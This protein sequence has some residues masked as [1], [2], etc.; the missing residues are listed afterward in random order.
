MQF[1]YW[2]WLLCFYVS[3]IVPQE[4]LKS[5]WSP[6]QSLIKGWRW[7]RDPHDRRVHHPDTLSH[8]S[9]NEVKVGQTKA[10]L[11]L[12]WNIIPRR[13]SKYSFSVQQKTFILLLL[14]LFHLPLFLSYLNRSC[15][16]A[17]CLFLFLKSLVCRWDVQTQSLLPDCLSTN[18]SHA[19]TA[20]L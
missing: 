14:F 7:P 9:P 5:L 16:L 15:S 12:I 17:P 10:F 4:C 13:W 2:L 1:F 6:C 3:E 20:A 8:F 19:K 18:A 11:K